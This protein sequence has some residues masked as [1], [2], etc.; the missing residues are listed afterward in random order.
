MRD[1]EGE[2]L[3]ER[4]SEGGM[5]GGRVA[6]PHPNTV[7]GLPPPPAANTCQGGVR[8]NALAR[9]ARSRPFGCRMGMDTT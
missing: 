7:G 2:R 5:G 6:G 9:V 3:R 8:C 4:L 1:G